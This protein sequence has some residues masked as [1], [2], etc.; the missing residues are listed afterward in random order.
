MQRPEYL[1]LGGERLDAAN[2]E[3]WRKGKNGILADIAD[4]LEEW[5]SPAPTVQLH[6]SGSTGKPSELTAGKTQLRASAQAT[7]LAFGLKHG[8]T[9]LL[10]L[11]MRY[12][13]GK[14]MVVRALEAG[15]AL[16]VTEPCSTPF[17]KINSTVDFAPLTPMQAAKTLALPGGEAQLSKGRTVLLG[18]GF[19]DP[20]L[21][22]KLQTC[23][24]R[25]FASYGMTETFSHIALRRIN[26]KISSDAYTPLPGVHVSADPESRLQISAP[27]LGITSLV[28][29]DLAEVLPDG[30]FRILGRKDSVINSGG[31]KIQAEDMERDLRAATG[32]E[33]AIVPCPHP[34]LGQCIALLWE[35]DPQQEAALMAACA[36]LPKYGKPRRILRAAALPRTETGKISRADCAAL[37]LKEQALSHH[38][39]EP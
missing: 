33:L 24:S 6:T 12:I 34:E 7:C 10:A 4:F 8:D 21:E 29:N 11:P 2:L 37:F 22:Q 3:E 20:A 1:Q 23:P 14:M 30:R 31:I 5:F 16:I 17:A 26:G 13:A 15:L 32:L 38:K 9:A 27:Y 39:P 36:S 25:I 35:G 18:G 28:T 19:I